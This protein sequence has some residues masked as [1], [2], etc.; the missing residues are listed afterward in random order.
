MK[1][2]LVFLTIFCFSFSSLFSESHGITKRDFQCGVPMRFLPKQWKAEPPCTDEEIAKGKTKVIKATGGSLVGLLTLG[3]LLGIVIKGSRKSNNVEPNNES[4]EVETNKRME[5][6]EKTEEK[7]KEEANNEKL[8][9]L[10]KEHAP[11]FAEAEKHS[12][13]IREEH[14]KRANSEWS[15][16]EPVSIPEYSPSFWDGTQEDEFVSSIKSQQ[17][18]R[19]PSKV[20]SLDE[21]SLEEKL[22]K[23]NRALEKER[24]KK[25]IREF[26]KRIREFEDLSSEEK[27]ELRKKVKD[28]E[29]KN[30]RQTEPSPRTQI[31]RAQTD[32]KKLKWDWKY[33][34]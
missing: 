23:E 10:Q 17:P 32:W 21:I 5:E 8:K 25:R 14:S 28:E 30:V 22:T 31:P 24:A 9:K 2:V 15:I 33:S 27:E 29:S 19:M 1:K 7:A 13:R 16:S 20:I 11:R 4:N 34:N 26:E 12:K 6:M 18:A 3:A